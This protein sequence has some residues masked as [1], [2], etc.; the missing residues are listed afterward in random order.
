MWYVIPL[1]YMLTLLRSFRP[2]LLNCTLIYSANC[3][4]DLFDYS[5]FAAV[6]A[7]AIRPRRSSARLTQFDRVDNSQLP[8]VVTMRYIYPTF[9]ITKQSIW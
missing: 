6:P 1:T 3:S 4:S 5:E 9:V 2:P 8:S 7:S